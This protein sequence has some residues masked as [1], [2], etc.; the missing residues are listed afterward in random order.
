MPAAQR[1]F[2]AAA[3]KRFGVKAESPSTA[4]GML[5]GGNQQKVVLARAAA[6]QPAVMLLDDPTRGVDVGA[7]SGIYQQII[8]LAKAGVAVLLTSSDTDEVL[9]MADRVYVLRAGRLVGEVART[10]FD[11]EHILHLAAA[12]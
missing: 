2:A 6:G 12:G 11:R 4:V 5:S 1:N 9:A 3:M 8:E 7:K 10:E